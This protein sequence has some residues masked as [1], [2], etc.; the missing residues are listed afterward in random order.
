M[1]NDEDLA[2]V[3][4]KEKRT[5]ALPGSLKLNGLGILLMV[6]KSGEKTTWD[7]KTRCK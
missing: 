6:Q 7:Y 2:S 4:L 3:A 5:N 1:Q